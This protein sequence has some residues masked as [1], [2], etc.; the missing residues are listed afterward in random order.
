M[1]Q[2]DHST[3]G[4]ASVEP[5]QALQEDHLLIELRDQDQIHRKVIVANTK[6]LLGIGTEIT[7]NPGELLGDL[8]KQMNHQ[9]LTAKGTIYLT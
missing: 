8:L 6:A 4:E 5:H 2:A 1:D 3:G 9:S 7:A